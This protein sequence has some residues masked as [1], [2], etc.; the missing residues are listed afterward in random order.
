VDD[1]ENMHFLDIPTPIYGYGVDVLPPYVGSGPHGV[2]TGQNRTEDDV[3]FFS[4]PHFLYIYL[5]CGGVPDFSYIL[6]S[7]KK[8]DFLF[9]TKADRQISHTDRDESPVPKW[10]SACQNIYARQ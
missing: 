4:N 9:L 1:P 7:F 2:L 3:V 5:S 6:L 10:F 8:I